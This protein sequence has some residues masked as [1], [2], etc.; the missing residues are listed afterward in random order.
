M[1]LLS[2]STDNQADAKELK[3]LE[4]I[5]QDEAVEEF[6]E[7]DD[8]KFPH[9]VVDEEDDLTDDFN[10]EKIETSNDAK[11]FFGRRRA[12]RFGRKALTYHSRRRIKMKRNRGSR[13]RWTGWK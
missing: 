8:S 7:S 13:R 6:D 3:D 11:G 2:K 9:D 1:I 5:D 12:F 4:S 10:E